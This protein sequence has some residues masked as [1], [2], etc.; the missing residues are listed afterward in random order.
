MQK[1]MKWGRFLTCADVISSFSTCCFFVF[2]LMDF[3]LSSLPCQ[4]AEILIILSELIIL[5]LW[6]KRRT[7]HCTASHLLLHIYI[8]LYQLVW[9]IIIPII[10]ICLLSSVLSNYTPSPSMMSKQF[11]WPQSIMTKVAFWIGCVTGETLSSVPFCAQPINWL[12]WTSILLLP[13]STVFMHTHV[14]FIICLINATT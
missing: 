12:L 10:T 4:T 6:K 14:V 5:R 11:G 2:V 13:T 7:E 9:Y 3:F 1:K 8:P